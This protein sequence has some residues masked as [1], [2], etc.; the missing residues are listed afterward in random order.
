MYI[1]YIHRG[2]GGAFGKGWVGNEGGMRSLWALVSE[3]FFF[4]LVLGFWVTVEL[5]GW[6]ERFN[7][8]GWDWEM[9]GN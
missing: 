9:V 3:S 5:L 6:L 4:F 8:R 1:L 7:W 2:L